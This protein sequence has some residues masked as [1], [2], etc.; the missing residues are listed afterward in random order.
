MQTTPM[1]CRSSAAG[2]STSAFRCVSTPMIFSPGMTSSSSALLFGR[3]TFSGITVP[4][5]T[6]MLRIGRIGSACGIVIC[7]PFVPARIVVS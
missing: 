5:K 2:S 6:T 7:C 1:A 3:P 4:G